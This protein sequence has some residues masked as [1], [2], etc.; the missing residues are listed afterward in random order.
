VNVEHLI[1]FTLRVRRPVVI[2]IALT[3]SR[4]DFS[5]RDR[6][7]LDLLRPHLIQAYRASEAMTRTQRELG[8]A[9]RQVEPLD[10]GVIVL[11][12]D[13]R[14]RTVTARA[15]RCLLEFFGSPSRLGHRLPEDLRRWVRHQ[16]AL[17]ARRDDMP[18]AR[19]PLIVEREGKALVVRLWRDAGQSLLLLEEH[20]TAPSEPQALE[21]LG[22]SRREAEVLTWVAEGKTNREIG[23]ILGASARTVG[24]HVERILQKLG[25]ETRTAAAARALQ[26]CGGVL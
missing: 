12:P 10:R 18:G 19:E 8:L 15:S 25:V 9:G 26:A 6:L 13:G 22:L 16:D 17:L 14:V 23:T 1:G 7:C 11:T 3:R 20:A 2:G 21:R 4:A 24:K 5:E